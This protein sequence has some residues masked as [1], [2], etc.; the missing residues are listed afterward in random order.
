MRYRENSNESEPPSICAL[1]Q[2]AMMQSKNV[3]KPIDQLNQKIMRELRFDPRIASKSLAQKFDV[4]EVTIATRI[5]AMIESKLIRPTVFRDM[6]WFGY[7]VYCLLDVSVLTRS[8]LDIA[9]DINKL[10]DVAGISLMIGNPAINV[11][12][13]TK[14]RESLLK[15]VLEPLYAIV[16][17]SRVVID[18]VTD[19]FKYSCDYGVLSDEEP[20]QAASSESLDDKLVNILQKDARTSYREI[21][22]QVG[23]SESNVR[24]RLKRLQEDNLLLIGLA[25][26]PVALGFRYITQI[27]I[28]TSPAVMRKAALSLAEAENA[29]RVFG[30]SGVF[31]LFCAC[32]VRNLSEVDDLINARLPREGIYQVE[33]RFENVVLRHRYDLVRIG[34]ADRNPAR[35][36]R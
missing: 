13:V 22:R 19:F 17:V 25:I 7:E 30:M 31:N 5:R 18:F 9:K 28:A 33:I 20:S 8:A 3:G 14:S 10:S 15:N 36:S 29:P 34:V 32:I 27:R 6:R 2:S 12:V 24:S 23:T 16:G 26:N 35:Q 1:W 21:A 4:T 11:Q